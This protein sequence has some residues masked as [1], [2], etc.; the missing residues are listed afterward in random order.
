MAAAASPI[1]VQATS[2]QD[3]AWVA[4]AAR[5]KLFATGAG[6]LCDRMAQLTSESLTPKQLNACERALNEL[7]RLA[8]R[9]DPINTNTLI[10]LH[11]RIWHLLDRKSVLYLINRNSH[12]RAQCTYFGGD[13]AQLHADSFENCQHFLA[14]YLTRNLSGKALSGGR[15][16]FEFSDDHHPKLLQQ[17]S[18]SLSAPHLNPPNP[19]LALLS[20]DALKKEERTG[21]LFHLRGQTFA[22]VIQHDGHVLIFDPFFGRLDLFSDLKEAAAH[23]ETVL[24]YLPVLPVDPHSDRCNTITVEIMGIPQK[25]QASLPFEEKKER[26]K[27]TPPPSPSQ[28]RH[29]S[30]VVLV[31]EQLKDATA[32]GNEQKIVKMF[33]TL[34]EGH[35]SA[36][37]LFW[38]KLRKQFLLEKRTSN[39]AYEERHIPQME[40]YAF[41]QLCSLKIR[42][43]ALAFTITSL[44]S[45]K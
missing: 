13:W 40:D 6:S 38:E 32:H 41:F 24:F 5:L 21:F 36:Y 20:A 8:D 28:K 3:H 26:A 9:E 10:L 1:P 33:N 15:K 25:Q 17:E 34:K 29:K 22:T 2:E 27:V 18:L 23:L 4:R 14:T 44:S 19:F 42:K 37:Q 11:K 31:L 45:K 30:P 43:Q 7:S 12:S 35:F 39:S 16:S